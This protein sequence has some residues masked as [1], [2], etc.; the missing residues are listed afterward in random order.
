MGNLSC[1]LC[2]HRSVAIKGCCKSSG[3]AESLSHAHEILHPQAHT[4][5]HAPPY[6]LYPHIQPILAICQMQGRFQGVSWVSMDTVN[7]LGKSGKKNRYLLTTII[8]LGK[9]K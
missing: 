1:F 9:G 4:H 2:I 3:I 6:L 8:Q 5:L 7:K